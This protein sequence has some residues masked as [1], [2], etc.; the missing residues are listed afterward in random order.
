MQLVN[1][2]CA[3]DGMRFSCLSRQ[4]FRK[5][6]PHTRIDLLTEQDNCNNKSY[7]RMG[8]HSGIAIM[9][10]ARRYT[11]PLYPPDRVDPVFE[12]FMVGSGEEQSGSRAILSSEPS[13]KFR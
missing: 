1:C 12:V 8:R 6:L 9:C 5:T 11:E 3:N 7:S 10:N 13:A 4:P 2:A